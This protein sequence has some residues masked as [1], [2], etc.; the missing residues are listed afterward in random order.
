MRGVL[1]ALHLYNHVFLISHFDTLYLTHLNLN[2][3]QLQGAAIEALAT[4]PSN[5]L[6]AGRVYYD[7]SGATKIFKIHDGTNFVSITGDITAV[8]SSTTPFIVE[9]S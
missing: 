9:N 6:Q 3:N 1:D 5:N 8:T 2:G 7:T 4:A